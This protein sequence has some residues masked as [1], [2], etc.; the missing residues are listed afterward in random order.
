MNLQAE[1]L[2]KEE[3]EEIIRYGIA[4]GK[5]I[6]IST[7][8]TIMLGWILG[9]I[10]QSI[11]FWFSLGILRRYAGGYHADTEKS[12]FSISFVIVLASLFCIKEVSIGVELGIAIQTFCLLAIFFFF[13]VENKNHI[14]DEDERR[15]YGFRVKIIE[16]ILY[17]IYIFLSLFGNQGAVIS[18]GMANFVVTLS[19]FKKKKKNRKEINKVK[20]RLAEENCI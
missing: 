1:K 14:L 12:C 4:R 3:Q 17:F 5:V 18:L 13:S 2:L 10:W 19:L 7:L 8:I 15:E 9:V 16:I 20:K 6:L 11:I